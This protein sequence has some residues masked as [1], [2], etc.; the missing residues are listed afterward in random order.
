MKS[1]LGANSG[2][3]KWTLVEQKRLQNK[4]TKILMDDDP[5]SNLRLT[6][7]ILSPVN[8]M[9]GVSPNLDDM[10]G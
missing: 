4:Q 2:P 6:I 5:K 8:L 1:K 7:V 3:T 10:S 9:N